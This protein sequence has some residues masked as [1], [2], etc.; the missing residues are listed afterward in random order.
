MVRGTSYWS[1]R[2][3]YQN[4]VPI[5]CDLSCDVTVVGAGLTGLSIGFHLKKRFPEWRVVILE[6]ENVGSGAS[7]RSGGI[8]VE[9]PS[10]LGS[11]EDAR[12]L[13]EFISRHR[14]ACNVR[15]REDNPDQSLLDPFRLTVGLTSVCSAQGVEI[16]E[17]SPVWH[18]DYSC[19]ILCG[20]QFL[21]KSKL[22]ILAPDAHAGLPGSM[23]ITPVQTSV[24]NCLAVRVPSKSAE[25]L[26]WVYYRRIPIRPLFGDG[27]F[28]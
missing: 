8:I 3:Q 26:P 22:V 25:E 18:V 1:G 7:G 4:T 13:W 17:G 24:Q 15:K 21:V 10:L 11:I 20:T 14:I 6:A 12:Y 9:D 2:T 27:S 5:A 16:Y 23:A 19:G 28:K